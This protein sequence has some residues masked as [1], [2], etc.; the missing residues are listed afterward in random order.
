MLRMRRCARSRRWSLDRMVMFVRLLS[1]GRN[2]LVIS[3][4]SSR[5]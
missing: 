2:G 3:A 4:L 1:V 5:P